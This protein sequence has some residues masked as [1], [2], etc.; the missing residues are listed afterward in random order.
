MDERI[1]CLRAMTVLFA[2]LGIPKRSC[3]PLPCGRLEALS[4]MSVGG[5]WN[6]HI[7]GLKGNPLEELKMFEPI[8]FRVRGCDSGAPAAWA[9]HGKHFVDGIADESYSVDLGQ[10]LDLIQ[11]NAA[12]IMTY[13][14]MEACDAMHKLPLD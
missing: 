8:M 3:V 5:D 6:I 1:T 10:P 9:Q 7:L 11:S 12:R 4:A 14:I 13:Q 2:T